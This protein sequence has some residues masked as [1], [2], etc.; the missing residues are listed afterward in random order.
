MQMAVSLAV[1]MAVSLA[2]QMA[3]SPA[4]HMAVSLVVY[5]V[6]QMVVSPVV[7][8]AVS[9]AVQTAVSLAVHMVVSLAVYTAVQMAVTS[10]KVTQED[11][12]SPNS[13]VCLASFLPFPQQRH[14]TADELI[15]FN[16]FLERCILL[17]ICPVT[18][19]AS[20]YV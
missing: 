14:F 8:M 17:R 1:H 16:A 9:L 7:H 11:S 18:G 2:V 13:I 4:V 15:S 6:V 3:V 20:G 19:S 5:T 12:P 10:S